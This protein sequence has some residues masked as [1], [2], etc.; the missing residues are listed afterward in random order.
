[1][2]S[3]VFMPCVFP[4]G[5]SLFK[6]PIPHINWEQTMFYCLQFQTDR[7]QQT[8]TAIMRITAHDAEPLRD[9]VISF[10]GITGTPTQ[11]ALLTL[12][13]VNCETGPDWL[14]I[15]RECMKV[16][17]TVSQLT[18]L[19][20]LLLF[21]TNLTNK[22]CYFRTTVLLLSHFFFT[23]RFLMVHGVFIKRVHKNAK[24]FVMSVHPHGTTRIPVDGFSWNSIFEDFSKISRKKFH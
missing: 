7:I 19:F 18:V 24:S 6:Q 17:R 3:G 10:F 2:H 23:L 13:D 9:I 1:M 12:Q 5:Q 15:I 20:F 8:P 22:E 21:P 11:A 14:D 16:P 4:I